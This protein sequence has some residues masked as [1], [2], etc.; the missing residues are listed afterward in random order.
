MKKIFSLFCMIFLFIGC[1]N[2]P[3]VEKSTKS[4]L[5]LRNMQSKKILNTDVKFL[6]KAVLQVLLDDEFIIINS[7]SNLGYFNAKKKLDGGKESYKFA[8]YDLYYPIAI[9]K[10]ST[11]DS[12]I[13]EINA[14][15][16]IRVY[17]DHSVIRASFN[18]DILDEDGKLK[19]SRTIE[20][21]EF[22]QEFFA[23]VDKALFLERNN[24]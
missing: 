1:S 19:S 3:I 5:E 11:L 4:Q 24:L 23:K 9:Y 14:T 8:W 2:K 16:S 6:T 22:Y 18:S 10:L 13:K 21:S 15:V 17:E 12:L 20:E 7:D